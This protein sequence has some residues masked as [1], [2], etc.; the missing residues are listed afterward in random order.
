MAY[1]SYRG[2][3]NQYGQIDGVLRRSEFGMEIVVLLAYLVQVTGISFDKAWQ[4]LKFVQNLTLKNSQG[5]EQARVLVQVRLSRRE[6]SS[7]SQL[8]RHS[9]L[10][11]LHSEHLNQQTGTRTNSTLRDRT[12]PAHDVR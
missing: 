2:P 9:M 1:D 4:L 11:N 5:D 8:R 10:F 3:K 12:P 6:A 7:V